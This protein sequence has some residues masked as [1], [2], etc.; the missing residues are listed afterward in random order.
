TAH[1]GVKPGMVSFD[2]S[3]NVGPHNSDPNAGPQDQWVNERVTA[4]FYTSGGQPNAPIPNG[5]RMRRDSRLRQPNTFRPVELSAIAARDDVLTDVGANG[6]VTCTGDW[7]PRPDDVD[8]RIISEVLAGKG[9]SRPPQTGSRTY[10]WLSNGRACADADGNGLPNAWETR[11]PSAGTP[12][13]DAD[14]D[15]YLN[16]EEF[17]NGTDPTDRN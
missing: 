15:G 3:G 10:P 6:G 11:F 12:A 2:V 1:C 5:L 8:R 4:C 14:G 13:A 9:P 16:I 7:V 17:V